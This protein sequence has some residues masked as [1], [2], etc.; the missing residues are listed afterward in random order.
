VNLPDAI[1]DVAEIRFGRIS[2]EVEDTGSGG[3]VN[4]SSVSAKE[5]DSKVHET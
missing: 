2:S 3:E 4:V 1:S 5:P